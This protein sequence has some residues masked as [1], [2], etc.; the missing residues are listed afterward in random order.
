MEGIWPI[1]QGSKMGIYRGFSIMEGVGKYR[2]MSNQGDEIG[3]YCELPYQE[4][5][6][7]IF[8]KKNNT[9]GGDKHC[10]AKHFK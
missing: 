8:H 4:G 3:I 7:N 5:N 1:M 10:E 2:R 6:R 9:Q